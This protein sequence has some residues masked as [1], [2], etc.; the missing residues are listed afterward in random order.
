MTPRTKRWLALLL[1]A[2]LLATMVPAALTEEAAPGAEFGEAVVSAPAEAAVEE[3]TLDLD[4]EA[5]FIEPEADGGIAVEGADGET[6]ELPEA[7][8]DAYT[9]A[10]DNGVEAPPADGMAI[11]ASSF[12]DERFRAAVAES[13]DANGDGVLTEAEIAAT[14]LLEVRGAASLEGIEFFTGLTGLDC[15]GCDI[16]TLDVSRNTA[17]EALNCS[18]N[19]MT[20]LTLGSNPALKALLAQGNRLTSLDISGC[21]QLVALIGSGEP[22]HVENGAYICYGDPDG[23][24]DAPCLCLDS[25]VRLIASAAGGKVTN[26]FPMDRNSKHTVY[27]NTT[28]QVQLVGYTATGWKSSNTKVA[29]VDGSGLVTALKAGT[30]KITATITKKKKLILTLTVKDPTLPG[31]VTI[32]TPPSTELWKGGTLRLA[33]RMTPS[34]TGYTP[35]SGLTW[36]SSNKKVVAVNKTTGV[37]TAK[38]AGKA[39]I[40][41]KTRNNKKHTLKVKVIDPSLPTGVT[42]L[43]SIFSTSSTSM[44]MSISD[45]RLQLNARVTSLDGNPKTKL[46]W[47]SSNKKIATVSKT[48]LVT[49]KKTGT[50]KITVSTS[51][52]KKAIA[53]LTIVP[54]YQ[55]AVSVLQTQIPSTAAVGEPVPLIFKTQYAT[56]FIA[57]YDG[58]GNMLS[59]WKWNTYGVDWDCDDNDE[60]AFWRVYYVFTKPGT[61][62][63]TFRARTLYSNYGTARTATV[64]VSEPAAPEQPVMPTGVRRALCVGQ[65][66]YVSGASPLS[67][68][69]YDNDAMK[70]M[71]QGLTQRFSVRA[72]YNRTAGQILSDINSAFS[73]ATDSSVSLFYYS[74]HG[75]DDGSPTATY[76]GA[77]CGVDGSLLTLRQLA[78]AL[79]RV[80]GKVIV[81]LDSCHSGAAISTNAADAEDELQAFNRAAIDAFSSYTLEYNPDLP[82]TNAGEMATNKF[83]VI[84]ACTNSQTSTTNDPV[85]TFTL[86]LLKGL[87]MTFSG[88]TASYGGGAMPA[89]TNSDRQVTLGECFTYT[90]REA[91]RLNSS[92]TAMS[93][94]NSGEILFSRK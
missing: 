31:S 42:I 14:A 55:E 85:S 23:A 10:A 9:A 60:Y 2:L 40:T 72:V 62:N 79:S 8:E 26:T 90:K 78:N 88:R 64:T 3:T 52:K 77:L 41:V 27:M 70:V 65:A 69:K 44:S 51:N 25:D 30:A 66:N 68:C 76:Q 71:L 39:T 82:L 58:S 84:T 34:V 59:F 75:C 12:P 93:W 92:Q 57:M 38:K 19:G 6:L 74:G 80:P 87:G 48:G 36:T 28:L 89:D 37:L 32:V 18:G 13:C 33:A 83:I 11:D 16:R 91:S 67:T 1:A 22:A 17:L 61:Y 15:S 94:G 7:E 63:L 43:Q 49:A 54:G 56:D 47:T 53:Y 21:P 45:K 73:D 29:T 35:V 86:A 20:A 4:G 5:A 50:V 81:L 46:T 24:A